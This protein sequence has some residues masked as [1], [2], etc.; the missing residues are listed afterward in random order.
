MKLSASKF[1]EKNVFRQFQKK[2]F[3]SHVSCTHGRTCVYGR[4]APVVYSSLLSIYERE[5]SFI[6]AIKPI[7]CL[8]TCPPN[9]RF[10]PVPVRVAVPPMFAAYATANI[11]ALHSLL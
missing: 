4:Y 5:L 2:K 9:T 1:N 3:F 7:T 6:A 11:M 8:F 10:G